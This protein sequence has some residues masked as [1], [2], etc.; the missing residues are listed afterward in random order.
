M[1]GEWLVGCG[2]SGESVV[3]DRRGGGTCCEEDEEGYGEEEGCQEG[4]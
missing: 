1:G 2:V 3:R 4:G